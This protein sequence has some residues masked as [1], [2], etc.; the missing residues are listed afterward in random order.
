[1]NPLEELNAIVKKHY[2]P[3]EI[4]DNLKHEPEKQD[5]FWH[6]IPFLGKWVLNA[7]KEERRIRILEKKQAHDLEQSKKLVEIAKGYEIDDFIH[8]ILIQDKRKIG[9]AALQ[10][11]LLE[12]KVLLKLS[13]R[14]PEFVP[15]FAEMSAKDAL[16]LVTMLAVEMDPLIGEYANMAAYQ[17]MLYEERLFATEIVPICEQWARK[18]QH[19]QLT[20]DHLWNAYQFLKPSTM[21]QAALGDDYMQITKEYLL[22]EIPRIQCKALELYQAKI[23]L[24]VVHHDW[25][26]PDNILTFPQT[27]FSYQS[28]DVALIK[29]WEK[30]SL[31]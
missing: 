7:K 13:A 22:N 14:K 30:R 17:D 2:Q 27:S 25:A 29:K 3:F 19:L 23:Q 24:Q 8:I 9:A 12:R 6:Y 15:F 31:N 18:Y 16:D 1:M 21:V 20:D 11:E 26:K 4:P 28:D 10:I 5:T